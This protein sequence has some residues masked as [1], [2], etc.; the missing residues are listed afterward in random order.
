MAVEGLDV[1]I[2]KLGSAHRVAESLADGSIMF[3]NLAAPGLV[4]VVAKGADLVL[5]AGGVNQQFLVGRPGATLGNIAGQPMGAS[6]PMDL[7]HFLLNVTMERVLGVSSEI[8]WIDGSRSRLK[9]LLDES[10]AACT[11]SPPVAIEAKH[12]GLPW[13]YDYADLG[14]N[15]AIGGIAVSRTI[16]LGRLRPCLQRRLTT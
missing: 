1:T 8:R 10:I 2:S 3:G 9:A 13:L 15:F 6:R 12:A 14:L 11:L 7:G 5:I 4:D 16:I